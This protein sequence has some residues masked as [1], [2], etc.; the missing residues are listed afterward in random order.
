M[1]VNTSE[2][3]RTNCN[4]QFHKHKK[5]NDYRLHIHL[6][7]PAFLSKMSHTLL[8]NFC[9]IHSSLLKGLLK[10]LISF[11]YQFFKHKTTFKALFV[12]LNLPNDLTGCNTRTVREKQYYDE[13]LTYKLTRHG[14]L[15]PEDLY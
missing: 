5:D 10:H 2:P 11:F 7:W 9:V 12:L 13:T 14:K 8:E 15:F 3:E 1:L 6:N 4:T